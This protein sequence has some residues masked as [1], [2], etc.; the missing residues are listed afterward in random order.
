[1]TAKIRNVGGSQFD[2]EIGG[3]VVATIDAAGIVLGT[4]H[5]ST[6][7]TVLSLPVDASGYAA[8]GGSTGTDSVTTTAVTADAPF[9]ATAANG[10]G[11]LGAKNVIGKSATNLTWTG[12]S[13]AGTWG[14]YADIAAGALVPV[15]GCKPLP[16]YQA[17]GAF[18]TTADQFTYNW[19]EAVGKVGNGASAVQTNRVCVGEVVVAGGVVTSI[20]WYAPRG[21]YDSGLF[22]VVAN[23]LYSK[24]ANVGAACDLSLFFCTA[25]TGLDGSGTTN[26]EVPYGGPGDAGN[27]NYR[28][29]LFGQSTRNIVRAKTQDIFQIL[30][31][32]GVSS[33]PSTGYVRIRAKRRF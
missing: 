17:G 3:I 4:P 6:R 12:L 11:A 13:T 7:Q 32:A 18:S 27:S 1:M 5:V 28:G 29:C 23:T 31:A 20:V 19:V 33:N 2:V 16:R 8:P 26:E 10:F 9:V 30:D 24:N 15:N 21:E 25:A 22:A 14:L